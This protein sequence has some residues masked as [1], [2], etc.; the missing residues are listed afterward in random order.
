[1]E[2]VFH[3]E[4]DEKSMA[5]KSTHDASAGD[6]ELQ[7]GSDEEHKVTV[8]APGAEDVK[9]SSYRAAAVCLGL[10]CLLL[11]FGLITLVSQYTKSN[12][13]REMETVLLQTS[14]NNLAEERDQ[15]Q[16]SYNNL[17]EGRDQLQTSYNNLMEE[18]NQ[19]QTS[20]NN[21]AE[22]RDQLQTSY[23]NLAEGR[24]QLQTSYNNLAEERDQLQTSSNNLTKERDQLQERFAVLTKNRNDLQRKLQDT[25][26]SWKNMTK[27]TDDL[28]RIL[29]NF[30]W[31]Y[32]RGSFY[33]VSSTK[34][35]WQ[36][37]RDDC[38]LKGAD[39]MIINSKEEEA[40]SRQFKKYMWIGLTDTETEGAW[41]WVDGTPVTE[42][43]WGSGE[44]NGGRNENCGNI[45]R[46][47]AEK[48]WNDE[49]CSYS[50]FWI[51]EKKFLP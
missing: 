51:C 2:M 48:S 10:L 9:K 1:M 24:D 37:S 33:H 4:E 21:L 20:F 35:T 50:C 25:E 26:A 13:E 29:K 44:P 7:S 17:A 30:E 39:L 47:D 36:E 12:S 41:K 16:T 14:Y 43:Y 6:V 46:Y 27:E 42:R 32:F 34:K 22:G 38:L 5:N 19:L 18:R 28:K 15:L 23:N 8:A 31:T 11:L 49:D 40:F 3:G 45:K